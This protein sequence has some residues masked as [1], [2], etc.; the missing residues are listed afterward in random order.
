MKWLTAVIINFTAAFKPHFEMAG[1]QNQMY[2]AYCFTFK[3][4]IFV[5][6]E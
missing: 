3:V 4:V 2:L 1:V 5:S 6:K